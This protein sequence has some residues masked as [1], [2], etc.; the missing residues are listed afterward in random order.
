MLLATLTA[1]C[2]EADVAVRLTALKALGLSG[3]AITQRAPV[4]VKGERV[5]WGSHDIFLSDT[6]TVGVH[7][8]LVTGA[9]RDPRPLLFW[10][11]TQVSACKGFSGATLVAGNDSHD[12]SFPST[13]TVAKGYDKF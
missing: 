4:K 12:V 10:Q 7:E 5:N 3:E 8:A 13:S 1:I 6:A 9:V 2:T 11:V